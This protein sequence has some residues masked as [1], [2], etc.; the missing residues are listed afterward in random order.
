MVHGKKGFSRL[1]WACK[2]VLNKSLTWLFYNFNPTAKESLQAGKEPISVHQPFLQSIKPI[3]TKLPKTLVPN[4]TVSDLT[5]LYDRDDTLAL[6]EYIHM[7]SLASPRVSAYD[8]IDSH[9]SRY[10]VPKLTDRKLATKEMVRVRW[11]GFIGP[12][13]V[14]EIY[15][16]VRKEGLKVDR[17]EQDGEGGTQRGEEKRW[18]AMSAAAF[19]GGKAWTVMQWAGRETLVWDCEV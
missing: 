8:S 7:L 10:E 16:T 18:I 3:V 2:N 11:R 14:R 6:Q 1:E 15:L 13:F 12:E 9:I 17:N 19:G 5:A 4:L